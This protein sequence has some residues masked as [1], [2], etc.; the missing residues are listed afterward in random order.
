MPIPVAVR[1]PQKQFLDKGVTSLLEAGNVV[2]L[3]ELVRATVD[4]N[5]VA[6]LDDALLALGRVPVRA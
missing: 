3:Q 6:L 2:V 5:A 4:A 1:A